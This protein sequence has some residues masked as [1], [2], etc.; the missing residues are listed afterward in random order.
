MRLV[1]KEPTD[2]MKWA[3]QRELPDHQNTLGA[4]ILVEAQYK[5]MLAAAKAKP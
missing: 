3:M 1:P 4:R 5:A 2:D